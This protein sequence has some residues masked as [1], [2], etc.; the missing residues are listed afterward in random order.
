MAVS[1]SFKIKALVS[2]I[3]LQIIVFLLWVFVLDCL[4]CPWNPKPPWRTDADYAALLLFG[5]NENVDGVDTV[6]GIQIY[7][8]R[9]L[10]PR[11]WQEEVEDGYL[12]YETKNEQEIRSIV[13]SMRQ[14]ETTDICERRG[15]GKELS[16]VAFDNTFMRAAYFQLTAC[17]DEN[18]RH[19]VLRA[20][21]A[22]SGAI[23]TSGIGSSQLA[24]TLT[25]FRVYGVFGRAIQ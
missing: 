4:L 15:V 22:D 23:G 21:E 18:D 3:V 9:G 10:G 20:L 19:V 16:L 6:D 12:V 11:N 8:R 2:V 5:P 25:D 1:Y 17:W 7:D 13:S 24:E 14:H